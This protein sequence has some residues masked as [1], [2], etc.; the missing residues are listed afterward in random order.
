LRKGGKN[1]KDSLWWRDLKEVWSLE[2]WGR[3][4]EDAIKCFEECFPE[5]VFPRLFSLSLSKESKVVELG[6]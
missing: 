3:N 1:S 4:F 6:A 5:V 2:G